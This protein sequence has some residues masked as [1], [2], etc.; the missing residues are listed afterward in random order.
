MTRAAVSGCRARAL[1]TLDV[2]F[3]GH[4]EWWAVAMAVL[5]WGAMIVHGVTH[6]GHTHHTHMTPSEEMAH[7]ALMV[8][9]MMLPL[10]LEPLRVAAFRS[11]RVRRHRAMAAFL[12][13]YF[14]PWIVLGL[15]VI[16]LHRWAWTHTHAAAAAAFA[17][18]AIWVAIPLRRHALVACHRTVPLAPVGWRA[19]RDCLRYGCI[20]GGACVATC[21][22]LMLACTLTGHALPA[23]LGGAAV[24]AVERLSFRPPVRSVLGGIAA[25]AG[26]YLVL[27][28][29]G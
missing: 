13:G 4:P 10:L 29:S 6:W 24:G 1:H 11:L 28:I 15:P 9:A 17:L 19:D 23:M 27:A 8:A 26:C 21:W 2:F 3:W 18:A 12:A 14:A 25:L 5:A 22:P 16:T 20:I 7:W